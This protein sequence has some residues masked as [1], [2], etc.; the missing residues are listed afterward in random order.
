MHAEVAN[1]PKKKKGLL[2]LLII[3]FHY[4]QKVVEKVVGVYTEFAESVEEE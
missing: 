3:N 4:S 1:R 2:Y